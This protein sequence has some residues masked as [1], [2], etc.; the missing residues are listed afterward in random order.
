[1]GSGC[2]RAAVPLVIMVHD[3]GV[4]LFHRSGDADLG[5]CHKDTCG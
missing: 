3:A 4:V 2:M 1:M 5:V